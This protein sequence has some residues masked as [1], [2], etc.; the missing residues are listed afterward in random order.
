MA[1]IVFDEILGPE[2]AP[3]P[4]FTVADA[5]HSV[6]S[7]NLYHLPQVLVVAAVLTASVLAW[8]WLFRQY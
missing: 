1:K 8:V 2:V 3:E 5:L 7:F 6:M 4:V